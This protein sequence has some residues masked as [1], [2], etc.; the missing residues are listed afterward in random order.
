M[1]FDRLIPL[2]TFLMFQRYL[3]GLRDVL[4]S[5]IMCFVVLW[6]QI[7]SCCLSIGEIIFHLFRTCCLVKMIQ[8]IPVPMIS[9]WDVLFFQTHCLISLIMAKRINQ[10]SWNEISAWR[11]FLENIIS[12]K[13]PRSYP[14][15]M[16]TSSN[17]NIF[18]VIGPFCG[19][20]TGHR[21]IPLTKASDAE[22]WC[23]LWSA[24]E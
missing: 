20:F 3:S 6:K 9:D 7:K 14:I 16:M 22:L 4:K 18:R 13:F 10:L 5:A 23:F 24:P 11:S 2:W 1:I 19:E 15:R 8:D 12:F 17:G 21:W